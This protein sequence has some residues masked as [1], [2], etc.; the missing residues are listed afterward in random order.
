MPAV[1]ESK[2]RER[3]IALVAVAVVQVALG[4]ALISGLRVNYVRP[5]QAAQRLIAFVLEK[6]PPPPPLTKREHHAVAAP[7][8]ALSPPGSQPTPRPAPAQAPPTPRVAIEPTPSP[9]AGGGIGAA[10]GPGS[11]GGAGGN[12][13]G[14]GDDGG[15]DL[16][17]IGGEIRSSDYPRDL[18]ERGV[19]GRVGV[20]FTVGPTGRVTRCSV[21]RSS[22]AR[23]LDALTCRLIMQRF[24]YRPSTDRYGRPIAD[25]VE[26]EHDWIAR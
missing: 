24:V 26:G 10:S 22:G 18:R 9:A 3:L 8:A 7:K 20:L 4:I 21:T 19:G 2:P 23:E 17:Q 25:E 15:A 14:S 13:A 12:G 11:G 1:L 5:G 6:P 16:Q